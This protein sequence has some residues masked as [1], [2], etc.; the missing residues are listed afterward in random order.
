MVRKF[1][2]YI[3]T[4][5]PYKESISNLCDS[6]D[7]HYFLIKIITLRTK[8]Y[9]DGDTMYNKDINELY[10]IETALLRSQ[11]KYPKLYTIILKDTSICNIDNDIL[12]NV[13][14]DTIKYNNSNSWDICYL[15][16]WLDR[17]D[18]CNTMQSNNYNINILQTYSP[19]GIQ[20]IMLSPIGRD[21]ILGIKSLINGD[22]FT[23]INIPLDTKLNAEIENGTLSAITFNRN[24]FMYDPKCIKSQSDYVKY[25]LCRIPEKENEETYSVILYIIVVGIIFLLLVFFHIIR[26][27]I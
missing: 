24:I 17:C 5:D 16:R 13:F 25:S 18:K 15:C 6:F 2:V 10:R 22:Y 27:K 12:Y 19:H 4:S 9:G 8:N 3:L 26:K 20:S 14:K 11:K 1:I 23:P 21:R 7:S